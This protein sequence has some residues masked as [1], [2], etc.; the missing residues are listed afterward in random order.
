MKRLKVV[1]AANALLKRVE[2]EWVMETGAERGV[3]KKAVN[4]PVRRPARH[5]VQQGFSAQLWACELV[6]VSRSS[7]YDKPRP[8]KEETELHQRKRPGS[9][10]PA[11]P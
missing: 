5:L 9:N 11:T 1:E 2:V 8:P 4:S 10:P 7:L 6:G 3:M